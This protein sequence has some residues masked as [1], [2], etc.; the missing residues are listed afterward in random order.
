MPRNNR[1]KK[2]KIKPL[3]SGHPYY[4]D[5]FHLFA[6][7]IYKSLPI[8]VTFKKRPKK[9]KLRID[10]GWFYFKSDEGK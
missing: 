3:F 2:W 1:R 7:P 8:F 9:L 5:R 6:I 4:C 10:Q